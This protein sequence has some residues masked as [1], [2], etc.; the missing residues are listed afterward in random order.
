MKALPPIVPTPEQLQIIADAK[1][2]VV[3]I[4][5]AAGSGKTTIALLRLKQLAAFWLARRTRQR[6]IADVKILVIT[7]NRTLRGYIAD[8][9][10]E[11]LKGRSGLDLTVSTFAKWSKEILGVS[12]IAPEGDRKAYIQSLCHAI[13]LPDAFLLDEVDY[14]LGRFS[15][16][17]VRDYLTCRRIGR[18]G[19]PRLDSNL[20]QRIL[21]EIVAPYTAWKRSR[22]VADWNDLA[23]R[24]IDTEDVAKYDVIIADESQDLSANQIRALI[25]CSAKP[26]SVTFVMDAAQRIYPRG[27]TWK[28]VGV[29][30]NSDNSYRLG[31]NYRN[32]V[33]IC[34]F[35]RPLLDGMEIGDDGTFPDLNACGK[36]G[37]QPLVLKGRYSCQIAYTMDYLSQQ[38]DLTKESV[39]F[40]KPKGGRWFDAIKDA[41]RRNSFSFIEITR[42][43]EWPQGNESI[44][45]STM[46]SGKGLEFD[47]VIILGLN[48]EV[49][50]HESDPDDAAHSVLRRLLAMAITRARKGVVLGYKPS[51]ASK[52]I[53]YL[54]PGTYDEVNL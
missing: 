34:R 7:F 40:L 5:G 21:N 44:A 54:E 12:N 6:S 50:P 48:Q 16:A 15:I 33:E 14:L 41:L 23:M 27:F 10:C 36:H 28:E 24:V 49:T 17:D 4:R 46:S 37:A 32:T 39:A 38:V 52:L 8:L 53:Q 26:S 13:P 19:T 35:V 51:E 3:L 29:D 2:G 43:S 11:Q 42:E 30:I 9:A 1:P 22:G 47:H 31:R 25:H 18:G 45:I 20:R